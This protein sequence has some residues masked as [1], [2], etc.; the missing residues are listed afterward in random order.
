MYYRKIGTQ[1][2]YGHSGGEQGTTTD[3]VLDI[4]TGVGAIVFTNTST[5]NLDTIISSLIQ[6]AKKQ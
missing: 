1:N 6:Y 2:L 5:A 4:N 3:M